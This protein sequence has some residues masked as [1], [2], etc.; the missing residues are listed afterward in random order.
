MDALILSAGYGTRMRPLTDTLPKPLL[1]I[2]GLNLLE[3]HLRML[4]DLKF[5]KVVI[6]VS[7]LHE[8]ITKYFSNRNNSDIQIVFSVEEDEPLG[9]AGG[10]RNALPFLCDNQ[11]LVV[12]GDVLIDTPPILKDLPEN[13]DVHMFLVPNPDHHPEGDFSFSGK[14]PEL[15]SPEQ[16]SYTFSGIALYRTSMF[17]TLPTGFLALGPV[18][19]AAVRS[20]RASAEIYT[21]QWIDVGTVERFEHAKKLFG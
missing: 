18:L 21:G 6:N 14:T 5:K 9:T 17:A 1:R 7:Y 16:P 20:G 2:G 12:N 3:H 10:I 13:I 11:L 8:L 4:S 15:K 19:H